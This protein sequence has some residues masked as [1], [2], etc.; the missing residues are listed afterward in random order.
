MAVLCPETMA[1]ETAGGLTFT[2]QSP[3]QCKI[4]YDE[5]TLDPCA[6]AGG[7]TTSSTVPILLARPAELLD[8][9]ASGPPS[10]NGAR[11]LAEPPVPPD[12]IS[13]SKALARAQHSLHL[14]RPAALAG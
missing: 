11:T 1:I 2:S 3:S 5:G 7:G 12:K 4:T 6:A 9:D 14:P 10:S 8:G 13:P